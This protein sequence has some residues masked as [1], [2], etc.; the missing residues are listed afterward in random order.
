MGQADPGLTRS[1]RKFRPGTLGYFRESINY[2]RLRPR[3]NRINAEEE[4][5]LWE[6]RLEGVSGFARSAKGNDPR[7]GLHR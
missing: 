1:C 7:E 3:S 5:R 4:S 2:C 6:F